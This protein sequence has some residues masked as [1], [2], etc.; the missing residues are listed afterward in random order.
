MYEVIDVKH[1][2]K[3]PTNLRINSVSKNYSEY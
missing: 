1:E 2:K 3:A